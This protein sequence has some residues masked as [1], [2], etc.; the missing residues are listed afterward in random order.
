MNPRHF[1][2][3]LD[4][5]PGELRSLV[6]RAIELKAMQ[7]RHELFMPFKGHVMGMIF[8]KASTRTRVS[9]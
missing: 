3:L 8:E 1:L 9:F 2:T 4:F 5:E 7:R 6:N